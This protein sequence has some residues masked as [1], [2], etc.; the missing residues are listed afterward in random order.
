MPTLKENAFTFV[1]QALPQDTFTVVRFSGEEGLS[2]L[3]SFEILLVSEK[4]DVDLTAVL[5]NP[6]TFT[7][8]GSF[9]GSEDLPFHGILSGFE[10]MHQ[11]DTY[12]FYR[13]ELRPK[14]WWLTLTHHN[15]VFLDKKVDQFLGDVLRDGG[16]SP[17]LDF[18]FQFQNKYQPWEY[19]CQYG[20]SHFGFVSRWMEREGAY[21]W[22]EQGEQAEKMIASD[23]LVAHAPLPGHET[24]LYSPPSGLDAADADKVIKRFTLKQAPL[25]KNVLLKDYNYMKPSLDLE[26]KASV[27][28]KGRGEIYLYG[29]NF[30]NKSEGDR[31]ARVR[32]EEY[33]CREKVFHGLSSIPAVRPGY[34]FTLNRHFRDE[35][36]QQYLTTTVRHEGS[37]ERYLLSGLGIRDMETVE[38]LFYRNTFECIPS[39]TQ[40][41]PARITPKPRM[42]GTLSAKVDAAGSGKYAELDKHGRYKVILPFDLSGR[43]EGKASAYLR[44]MQPYAGEGMGFHAPL[45]KGT[46]VLLSFIEADPD[47][48]VIS[49][50]VPNP[51]TP[52]PVTD[53]NQTQVRLV[54]G[55]GNVMHMEDE[56]GKQRMLM[57]TPSAN[58]FIRIGAPNDPDTGST[59]P[60]KESKAKEE[61]PKTKDEEQ[62]ERLEELETEWGIRLF[63][64]KLLKVQA[65]GE[66]TIILGEVSETIVGAEIGIK[67][68][69]V[70]EV[71]AGLKSELMLGGQGSYHFPTHW[72]LKGSEERV[73]EEKL[74]VIAAKQ[75][76]LGTYDV[77]HGQHGHVTATVTGV[78]AEVSQAV[79]NSN[80]VWGEINRATGDIMLA[81]GAKTE[82][83]AS[84]IHA[85]GDNVQALGNCVRTAGNQLNN[86]G[87]KLQ[88]VGSD[89]GNSGS[90]IRSAGTNIKN[91][92]LIMRDA[93]VIMDN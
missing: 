35:F 19:V 18:V 64:D 55:S 33:R 59:E 85:V 78:S 81:V 41:R 6:A 76:A 13:A 46:E 30:P 50:A 92:G 5:Q 72:L 39:S 54:S 62:D 14:L 93:P 27:Q 40:Y 69:G 45:H 73:T 43:K 83:L 38:G 65:G 88:N 12:F 52:S 51:E 2:T 36:N 7:I 20:E 48:P 70:G 3:Y 74:E 86:A 49:G 47:R 42:A 8:K 22:F 28:D 16:L 17:G 25:P 57:H 80:E 26:G 37:Q 4:E 82:A 29:E 63:T 66:N 24:F 58:T 32:A 68:A 75:A 31:L 44:M 61:E 89:I 34:L 87:V 90:R 10:Q 79:A 15:Q 67:L 71:I 53:A 91:A 56:E 21:Y 23:T 60:K 84:R 1:S 9:S 77:V 11:A